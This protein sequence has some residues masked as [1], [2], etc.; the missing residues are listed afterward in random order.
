MACQI[1]H[2]NEER[3]LA[4]RDPKLPHDQFSVASRL[5][6][7]PELFQYVGEDA[8]GAFRKQT[9]EKRNI[10]HCALRQ[11]RAVR[12]DRFQQAMTLR[13]LRK[14]LGELSFKVNLAGRHCP[15]PALEL[16]GCSLRIPWLGE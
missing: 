3:R 12:E 9:G 5:R 11:E 13:M 15:V 16:P 1:G 4:P 6:E 10:G 2:G 7:C 8:S 14:L